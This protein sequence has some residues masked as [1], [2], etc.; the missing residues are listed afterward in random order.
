MPETLKRFSEDS[1]CAKCGAPNAACEWTA[2]IERYWDRD[3]MDPRRQYPRERYID[4]RIARK[5]PRCAW[6]W[7]E[8]PLDS[9]EPR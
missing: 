4:E 7:N 9:G 1:T 8:L 2:R 6:M 3:E 5:C